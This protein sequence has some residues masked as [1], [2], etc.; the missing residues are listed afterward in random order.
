MAR[1]GT[2]STRVTNAIFVRE[3][4]GLQM[5]L[6][7]GNKRGFASWIIMVLFVPSAV[8]SCLTNSLH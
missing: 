7:S 8:V 1:I 6:S 3:K 4:Y 2:A 5:V